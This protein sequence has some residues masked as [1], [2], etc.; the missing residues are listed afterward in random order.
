[1]HTP[2]AIM[3][4]QRERFA[5]SLNYFEFLVN[6]YYFGESFLS[7]YIILVIASCQYILFW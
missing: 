5:C 1:M 6:I 3:G 4:F 7:I 2:E